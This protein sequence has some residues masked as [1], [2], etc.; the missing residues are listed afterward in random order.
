MNLSQYATS[1][2]LVGQGWREEEDAMRLAREQQ[3]R[4]EELN[5]LNQFRQ[6]M[7]AAPMPAAPQ[8]D[9]ST[10]AAPQ[11]ANVSMQGT[12]PMAPTGGATQPAAPFTPTPLAA[13]PPYPGM[14][15]SQADRLALL[16]APTAALDVMQMPAAAGLNVA[17]Q[18][19]T[20][21]VNIGGRL[22]N[23]AW[24]NFNLNS[25]GQNTEITFKFYFS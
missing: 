7:T 14:S 10:M 2:G 1:A 18:L 5:R 15:Q 17:S 11:M 16:K 12:Q 21:V 22:I 19:G 13:A 25:N 23:A 20:G 24:S 3:L 9:L 6:E 4:T 8:Y